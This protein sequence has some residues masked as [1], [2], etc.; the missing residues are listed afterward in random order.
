MRMMMFVIIFMVIRIF[1]K[2]GLVIM[3]FRLAFMNR[4]V[5][6]I[7]LLTLDGLFNFHY[8]FMAFLNM[9]WIFRFAYLFNKNIVLRIFN[10]N[11]S[12][13]LCRNLTRWHFRT[14]KC[15]RRFICN[16][17]NFKVS[18]LYDSI[19]LTCC[20]VF[21]LVNKFPSRVCLAPFIKNFFGIYD[22][23]VSPL[24]AK[25]TCWHPLMFFKLLFRQR[26]LYCCVLGL[27]FAA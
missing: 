21:Y 12:C 20:F 8:F 10:R 6:V 27:T 17:Q 3:F 11:Y 13:L 18:N 23:I 15:F 19:T 14:W 5:F 25:L 4:I 24:S 22:F 7:V 1:R 26:M 16:L 2:I 9:S